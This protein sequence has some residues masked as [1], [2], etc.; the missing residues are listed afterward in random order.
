MRRAHI[1]DS[2]LAKAGRS[3]IE[4]AES[5]MPVL[6]QIRE[7]FAKAHPLKGWRVA[8]CLHVTTETAHLMLTLKAAARR[9]RC[10]RPTRSP[11]RMILRPAS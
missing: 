11:P 10:A 3:K 2:A 4:W 1:K 5:Q 9:S 6:L 7:R 8:C